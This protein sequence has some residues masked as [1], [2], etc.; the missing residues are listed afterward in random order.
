MGTADEKQPAKIK[1][2]WQPTQEIGIS[3][4]QENERGSQIPHA[5]DINHFKS[6][7][8]WILHGSQAPH[9]YHHH[10]HPNI[11]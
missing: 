1:F 4:A 7:C 9:H 11:E 6:E 3:E 5:L 10:H 2:I 8:I